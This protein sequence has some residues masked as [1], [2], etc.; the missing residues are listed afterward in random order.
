MGDITANFSYAEYRPRGEPLSWLPKT[1]LRK[2]MIQHNASDLQVVRDHCPKWVSLVITSG[3]R[4][5]GDTQ[6]LFAAGYRP[7]LT[8]DHNFGAPVPIPTTSR[9]FPICGPMYAMSVGAADVVPMGIDGF[10][11]RDLFVIAVDLLKQN[12]VHFGQVIYEEDPGRKKQW[13]HFGND[14]RV[15]YSEAVCGMIRREKVMESL[16]GGRTYMSVAV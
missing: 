5:P 11:A 12:I 9:Y 8:S 10:S 4:E 1:A 3:V 2:H 16:D 6:R 7:S 14:P 13:V 15:V